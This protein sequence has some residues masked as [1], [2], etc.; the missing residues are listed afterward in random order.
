MTKCVDAIVR[1]PQPYFGTDGKLYAP[2]ELVHDIPADLVSDK[3]TRTITIKVRN[4]ITREL[5]EEERQVPVKFRPAGSMPTVAGPLDPAEIATG[6]PDRLNTADFLKQSA[7]DI[8][9]AIA[10]GKVD[11]HLGAIEQTE[12]SGKGRKGVKDAIKARAAAIG[13]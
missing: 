3:D 10:S 9:A 2:G 7:E 6:Q 4:E 13:R 1:G 8:E 12:I 5:V 11:D